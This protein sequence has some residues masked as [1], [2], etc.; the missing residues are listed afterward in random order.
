[1]KVLNYSL[2]IG[3][4]LSENNG[5]P[6]LR[7]F[8]KLLTF[9][10]LVVLL[11]S[12]VFQIVARSEGQEH[13]FISGVYWAFVTMST[14]GYGDITFKSDLGQL[15]SILVLG[16]GL[17][18]LLVLLP[19]TFIEFFYAP[20][21]R[22]HQASRIQR[23]LPTTTHGHVLLT[24]YDPVSASLIRRLSAYG[25]PYA[26]LIEQPDRAIALRELGI[27][28]V[29]G[30]VDDP[31][32]YHN[33]QIQKAALVAATGPD[34]ANA[35]V[36]FTAKE[37]APQVRVATTVAS[38]AS[39]DVLQL[40]GSDHLVNLPELVGQGLARQSIAI[41]ATAHPMGTFHKVIIAEASVA[42]TPLVGKTIL[43]VKLREKTGVNVV[44]IWERG[45]F[46]PAGPETVLGEH[47]ILLLAGSK[48]QIETYNALFC[49][50]HVAHNPVVIIGSGRVG[51][52][53]ARYLTQ[54]AI[55]FKI[56]DTI[57]E[58][59]RYPERAV[60]GDAARLEVLAEAGFMEAPSVLI[61]PHNDDLNIYLAIYCRKLRPDIQIICRASLERNVRTMHRAGADFVLSY[62]ALGSNVIFNLLNRENIVVISDGLL[63]FKVTTP[64][65]FVGKKL[66]ETDFR[67]KTDCNLLAARTEETTTINPAADFVFSEG[68]EL[69]LLGTPEGQHEF[70]K[71]YEASHQGS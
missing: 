71:L 6:N 46:S 56:I 41:D 7:V 64:R 9:V 5:K 40:A 23:S 10:A 4:S 38:P 29:T 28:V 39:R 57:P 63:I 61:T 55:A 12:G 3:D 65:S 67:A 54:R 47:S 27:Q 49:I 19:F 32:T 70:L 11:Y 22:A 17:F 45:K 15:F 25:I 44:G 51:R 14:L 62:A 52:A 33:V 1:M 59:I 60:I 24:H 42:G 35:N 50:Y 2:P 13:S 8:F 43:E 66:A 21:V 69:I 37:A 53:A 26:L 31:E 18:L 48:E 30:P 36:A 20:W 34:T 68:S 16:T 58:R